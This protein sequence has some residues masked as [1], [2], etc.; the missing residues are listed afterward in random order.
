MSEALSRSMNASLPSRSVQR[1]QSQSHD[2]PLL[3]LATPHQ[4]VLVETSAG[5]GCPVMLTRD[6]MSE[7]CGC[8]GKLPGTELREL[9]AAAFGA[10]HGTDKHLPDPEDCAVLKHPGGDLLVTNDLGP[11]VGRDL[12][13]AGKIAALNSISDVYAMGGTPLWA[14]ATLIIDRASPSGTGASVL[15]GMAAACREEAVEV[16]GGQTL[17]GPES[18]AGLSV[19]G[20]INAGKVLAK[21]GARPGDRL[22]ISKPLGTGLVLRGYRLGLLGEPDLEVALRVMEQSNRYA[23]LAAV[24]ASASAATDVTGFGLLGHLAE[25]LVPD[26][27]G[28]TVY[29]NRVPVLA[30]IHRLPPSVAHTTWITGNLEYVRTSCRLVG[31]SEFEKIVALLD[32]QT[33][34]GLL[35]AIHPQS[36]DQLERNG[37][38]DI[39]V[40]TQNPRL[41]V[42]K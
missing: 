30:S 17:I 16:V 26:Q 39:G 15:A 25:M 19:I 37:F 20:R 22:M 41:E 33:S 12:F 35:V 9:L 4:E 11:L 23:S 38:I 40:I 6:E 3:E 10:P 13:R 28:A 32:P 1:S 29:L 14:L 42:V 31:V 2:S 27:L 36:A 34:G 5:S 18:M 7:R 24:Q 21:S 8:Q